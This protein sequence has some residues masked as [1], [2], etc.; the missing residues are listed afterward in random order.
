MQRQT[1]FSAP[2]PVSLPSV[3]LLDS[4]LLD[5][6]L[7]GMTLPQAFYTDA[8][9]FETDMQAVFQTQWLFVGH[10]CE[11]SEP[12]QYF[13]VEVGHEPLIVVRDRQKN[14]RAHFNVCRHR[15][16]K[17]T[18]K[19][20]G[21]TKALV[22]PY[23]GWTYELE[24]ELKAARFMGNSFDKAAYPLASVQV[25]E[26]AGL[27]FICLAD[28]PPDFEAAFAA[29]A[30]QLSPHGLGHTKVAVRD[31]YTINAN[32]K[33]IIENNRECYHC[34]VAH[35]EFMM[36][37]YDAGL[38]GDERDSGDRFAQ[39]LSESYRRW[40]SLGLSPKDVSFPSKSW[41]RVSRFPLKAGFVTESLDGQLTAPLMGSLT[42]ADV[43]SLRIISLPNFWA[44]A[45]ADYAMTTR[46]IPISASQTQIEV[47]F[48]VHADA[49]EGTDYNPDNVAAVWR[50][51]SEQDWQ[52][53]E[54]NYAGICS[55]A[56]RPGML[57]SAMESS[58]AAF[59][60]WY[61]MLLKSC[62][63]TKTENKKSLSMEPIALNRRV[64]VREMNGVF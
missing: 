9:V 28:D 5:S 13:T 61:L 34:Q 33:T 15:G 2:L 11:V 14:L 40:E 39:K 23:H 6:Y 49:V 44:H 26:L 10:S 29:I 31:R 35:P 3:S 1:S 54:N 57:S 46:V 38:P 22:C 37:N 18:S 63:K 19:Q 47:T 48:L 53:C 17:L 50:A 56:Y 55:S 27:V 7:P 45:N 25:R 41:F 42:D 64:K 43:G 21:C 32:W 30:P 60:D 52:L 24:G 16:S 51:T 20:A 36:A 4:D 58:V 59:L 12:G 8:S 62:S